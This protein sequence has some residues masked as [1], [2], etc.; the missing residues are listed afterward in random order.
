MKLGQYL[1]S[2]RYA[3]VYIYRYSQYIL[4]GA[5]DGPRWK[6]KL[7]SNQPQMIYIYDD[8][9]D[10][11]DDVKSLYAYEFLMIFHID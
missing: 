4:R 2:S 6:L 8:G 3:V 10:N 7:D 11:Y 5:S 1:Y 9:D